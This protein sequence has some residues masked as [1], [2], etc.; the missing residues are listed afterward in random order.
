MRTIKEI[1]KEI[2]SLEREKREINNSKYTKDGHLIVRGMTCYEVTTYEIKKY[3][4][5]QDADF[6]FNYY[7]SVNYE[8]LWFD[9]NKGI[10]NRRKSM[11][12]NFEHIEKSLKMHEKYLKDFNKMVKEY[13]EKNKI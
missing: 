5:P 3:V 2:E 10:E 12:L 13:S 4:I 8:N 9:L 1:N 6:K 7:T 11:E